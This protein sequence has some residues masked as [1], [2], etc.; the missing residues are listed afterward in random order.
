MSNK[1]IKS[2]KIRKNLVLIKETFIILLLT[3]IP[4]LKNFCHKA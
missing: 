3:V 2:T 4:C 1:G